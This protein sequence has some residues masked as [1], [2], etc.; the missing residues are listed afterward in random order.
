MDY[1]GKAG[2]PHRA[3]WGNDVKLGF[4]ELLSQEKKKILRSDEPRATIPLVCS[5]KILGDGNFGKN[6]SH[7]EDL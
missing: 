4:H 3:R 7:L 1:Y 2:S 5:L 6:I